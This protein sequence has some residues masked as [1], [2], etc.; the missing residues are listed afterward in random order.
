MREK[1]KERRVHFSDEIADSS[2]E[3]AGNIENAYVQSYIVFQS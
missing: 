2:S 1:K 3:T